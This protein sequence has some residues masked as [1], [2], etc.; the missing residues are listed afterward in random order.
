MMRFTTSLLLALLLPQCSMALTNIHGYKLPEE[1][2]G[3]YH[4]DHV[5]NRAGYNSFKEKMGRHLTYQKFKPTGFGAVPNQRTVMCPETVQ[6]LHSESYSTGYD[7]VWIVENTASDPVVLSYVDPTTGVEYSALNAKI[8]P[9]QDD[10]DAILQPGY[11]RA[12]MTWEGHVFQA[13][14]LVGTAGAEATLG[15]VLLQHRTGLIPIGLKAQ[16]LICPSTDPEPLFNLTRAPEFAR[17]PPA[18]FRRCNT[19]DLGFRNMANCPLHGYYIARL[20]DDQVESLAEYEEVDDR[21][22]VY[23]E[24]FKFHLGMNPASEDFMWGWDSATKFEGTF[25]GHSFAFRSADNPDIL[26]ETHTL[27]P[28]RIPDCPNLRNKHQVNR[29][30]SIGIGQAVIL[31]TG[32]HQVSNITDSS[33]LNAT[34]AKAWIFT[35]GTHTARR[36]RTKVQHQYSANEAMASAVYVS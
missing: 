3:R 1:E 34:L 18:E 28:T 30:T 11:W 32:L 14:Q 4:G 36:R 20:N 31:P 33:G 27:R 12:L 19:I 26:V 9:P 21:H 24:Y 23:Q 25:V 8:T 15:P 5:C 10:P 35:N 29:V 17:T 22:P 13:R 7:T 2:S 6:D 16:D